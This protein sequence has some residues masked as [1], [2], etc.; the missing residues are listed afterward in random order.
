MAKR[1]SIITFEMEGAGPWETRSGD[2]PACMGHS[3]S[4]RRKTRRSQN[5]VS[6]LGP[7]PTSCWEA[8]ANAPQTIVDVDVAATAV[9]DRLET[10]GTLASAWACSSRNTALSSRASARES[11]VW[12]SVS[13]AL[14]STLP[15][16]SRSWT[17][18]ALPFPAAHQSGVRSLSSLR[19]T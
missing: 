12:P 18:P 6:H 4:H 11:G 3:W 14:T 8:L 9:E 2:L 15:V 5:P 19:S 7:C 1:E 10:A 16:L 13:L 17:I